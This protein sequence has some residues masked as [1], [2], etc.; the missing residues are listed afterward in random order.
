MERRARQEDSGT[1]NVFFHEPG[2]TMD[3]DCVIVVV[4][5]STI[6]ARFFLTLLEPISE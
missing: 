1:W 5:D 4:D 3:P 6:E 2:S